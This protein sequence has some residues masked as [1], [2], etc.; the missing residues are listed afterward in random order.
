MHPG[1]S[2]QERQSTPTDTAGETTVGMSDEAVEATAGSVGGVSAGLDVIGD[3]D[4][5]A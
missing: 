5:R 4:L 3:L 2:G 1:L